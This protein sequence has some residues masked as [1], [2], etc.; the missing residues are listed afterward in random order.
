[1]DEQ[2]KVPTIAPETNR[3]LLEPADLPA[4]IRDAGDAARF[5]FEEFFHGQIRNPF[6]RK[7][8]LHAVR[9]FSDWCGARNLELVRVTP[10][11][12]GRYLDALPVALPTRKLHW[13]T[14]AGQPVADKFYDGSGNVTR[15]WLP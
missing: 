2:S 1:M 13:C 10:A 6:T 3:T 7:A 4:L 9:M 12:V 11:D 15:K 8:Y 5:A 14:R